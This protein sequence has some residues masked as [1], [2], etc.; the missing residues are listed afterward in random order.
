MAKTFH[1][2]T[3]IKKRQFITGKISKW[4][5]VGES[6]S[7]FLLSWWLLLLLH[8]R[9]GLLGSSPG[10]FLLCLVCPLFQHRHVLRRGWHIAGGPRRQVAVCRP[11]PLG[12]VLGRASG[13]HLGCSSVQC[14]AVQCSAVQC[15]AVQCTVQECSAGQCSVQQ[16]SA[17]Q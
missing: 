11:L 16:C 14:R 4:I 1:I 3:K 13:Q 6:S 10:S 17:L 5:K 15:S 12:D 7:L 8:C 9:G 2:R